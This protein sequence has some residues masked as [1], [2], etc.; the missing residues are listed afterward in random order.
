MGGFVV[1]DDYVEPQCHK[2]VDE[3]RDRLGIDE[4]ARAHRLGRRR[5][6][7]SSTR[8]R[9]GIGARDARRRRARP[10]PP[11]A[12]GAQGGGARRPRGRRA[13]A[14]DV[15]SAPPRCRSWSSST[16]CGGRRPA[17]CTRC[18]APTRRASTT[19]TTRSIVVE[20]GSDEDQRLGEDYV[21]ELRPRVPLH[22]H[23]RRRRAVPGPGAQPRRAREPGRRPRPHDRRRPRA[24]PGRAA[25][26][27]GR[28][29][30]LRAG[31]RG[32]P[33]VVRRS[34][35]AGRRHVRRLRPA[36][37]GPALRRRSTGR[38]TATGCSRSATSSASATGSTACGRATASSSRGRCSSRSARSTRASPRR[39]AATP[40]SSS[41]SASGSSPDVSVSTILGE[42]S[43]HQ[44]H[45]GTTTNQPEVEGRRQRI[46]SYAEHY[47][48]IR[49]RDF[50]GPGKT[51]HYV[52]TMFTGAVPHPG[53]APHVASAF[54]TNGHARRSRRPAR[55]SRSRSPRS[56]AR[57]TPR[58]SGRNLA[59]RRTSWLGR[60]VGKSPSDLIAYQELI[61]EVRPDW[62][63]E[64]RTG[65]G[66]R[67]LFLASICELLGHGQVLSI[68]DQ[69]P[70]PTCPS[71]LACST[72][73]RPRPSARRPRR[74]VAE[75]VGDEPHGLVV[76]G[77]RGTAPARHRASSRPTSEFVSVGSYVDH[78]GHDR[79]RPPGVAELRPGSGRGGQADHQPAPRL[80]AGPDPRALHAQLQPGRLPQARALTHR[81]GRRPRPRRSSRPGGPTRPG[82]RGSRVG[83]APT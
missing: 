83:R 2:A 81:S 8:R 48:E 77:S 68:D 7:A 45:G 82:A 20:N 29:R 72:S 38:T 21:R 79:R 24:D 1:I 26:R 49:G 54:F 55:V 25:L 65:N 71:T 18:R 6:G 56:C 30:P 50:R 35:P 73:S 40:T 59:W 67:A 23:G 57:P 43:F 75:I 31:H 33:A 58:P 32:H 27:H 76:L 14:G 5:A 11:V 41:T 17:R 9:A 53:P 39:A 22:R 63:I 47:G 16:T 64:L 78:R 60:T 69:R 44:V 28:P 3:L 61:A 36:L 12:R 19:S 52:G 74:L 62:I 37:R 80:R 51:I 13:A 4:T 15:R 10:P 34:G 42:G 70:R 66:G 46:T